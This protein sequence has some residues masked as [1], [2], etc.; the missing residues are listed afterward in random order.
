VVSCQDEKSQIKN[1]AKALR[2][3]RSRLYDIAMQEQQKA[4]AQ[5]RKSQVGTGD[6]SEKIR[7]YNFPQNRVT[8]HRIGMTIYSLQ[9]FMDGD[10]G[11]M[12][13]ALVTHF[14]AE[15]LKEA[16]EPENAPVALKKS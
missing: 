5:N 15:K 10:A 14:Q 7:T 4:I 16:V 11:E 8:D 9:D 13:D 1:K 3:L 12:M 2:V 6:R